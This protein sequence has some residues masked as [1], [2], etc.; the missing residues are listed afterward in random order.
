MFKG[1][2]SAAELFTPPTIFPGGAQA[3]SDLVS[4]DYPYSA[5]ETDIE[6]ARQVMEEAGYGPETSGSP[7][8]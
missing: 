7:W 2:G 4:S 3:A 8:S 6:A 1:R 5:G